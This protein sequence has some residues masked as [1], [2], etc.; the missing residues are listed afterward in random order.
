MSEDKALQTVAA[1]TTPAIRQFKSMWSDPEL[2]KTAFNAATYFSKSDL[3]PRNVKIRADNCLIIIDVAN[4]TGYSPLFIAQQM[5]VVKGKPAWSGQAS[6]AL[7]NG[8]GRYSE[9]LKPIFVGE[10]G[11]PSW[12]CYMSTKNLKGETV[13]G[14][15]VTMQM[16]KDEAGIEKKRSK[17]KTMPEL[18]L[19]YRAGAFF[20]KGALSQMFYW[21][22]RPIE[23]ITRCLRL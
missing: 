10:V 8:S 17:W 23:E 12:G 3:V 13:V 2:L 19:Q 1:D 16:A 21:E 18:M 14:T 15:T 6:I 9:P 4:R 20:R 5:I 7:V 11:T 22:C